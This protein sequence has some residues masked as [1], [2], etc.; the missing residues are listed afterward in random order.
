MY[1]HEELKRQSTGKSYPIIQSMNIDNI[2]FSSEY[3]FR[4]V[5]Y[6]VCKSLIIVIVIKSDKI[7]RIHCK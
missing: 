6:V 2:Y 1:K 7:I 3:R 5:T 4:Q